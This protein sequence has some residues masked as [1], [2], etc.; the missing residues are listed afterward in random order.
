MTVLTFLHLGRWLSFS[1]GDCRHV[2]LNGQTVHVGTWQNDAKRTRAH[3]ILI[4][5]LRQSRSLTRQ[6]LRDDV[7]PRGF[8]DYLE[9]EARI[10]SCSGQGTWV[11]AH[12]ATPETSRQR[13]DSLYQKGVVE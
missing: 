10:V 9:L 2:V 11:V 3:S 13:R 6:H 1:G 5:G 8:G 7:G 4:H 12:Y